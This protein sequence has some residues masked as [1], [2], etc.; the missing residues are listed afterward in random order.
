MAEEPS[1]VNRR[2]SL[3]STPEAMGVD[4][5][6]AEGDETAHGNFALYKK[7]LESIE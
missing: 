7:L 2:L 5:I 3:V 6:E 1:V 4:F